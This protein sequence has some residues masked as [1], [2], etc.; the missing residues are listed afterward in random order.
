MSQ[1]ISDKNIQHR[2][3]DIYWEDRTLLYFNRFVHR[4]AI[5]E[6]HIMYNEKNKQWEAYFVREDPTREIIGKVKTKTFG[7]SLMA[8]IM[9][10][11][12]QFEDHWKLGTIENM[13]FHQLAHFFLHLRVSLGNKL[14]QILPAARYNHRRYQG[15][16]WKPVLEYEEKVNSGDDDDSNKG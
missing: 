15:K 9:S 4:F 3:A 7:L 11:I 16:Y 12:K 8:S 13:E 1:E 14:A 6:F 10:I 5:K 2:P